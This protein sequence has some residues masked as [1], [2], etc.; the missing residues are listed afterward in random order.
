MRTV[1]SLLAIYGALDQMVTEGNSEA[2]AIIERYLPGTTGANAGWFDEIRNF[3]DIP[4]G[5]LPE[6]GSIT[7]SINDPRGGAQRLS[8]KATTK[9]R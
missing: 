1:H 4:E 2:A 3:L 6:F 7:D 5:D 9:S 8:R